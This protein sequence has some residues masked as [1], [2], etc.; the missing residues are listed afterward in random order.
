MEEKEKE[1]NKNTIQS[2]SEV[3]KS[4]LSLSI[5]NRKLALANA[6]RVLAE[7]ENAELAYKY[8]VVQLYMKYGLSKDH[9]ITDNGEILLKE[10]GEN[11]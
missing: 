10:E 9:V 3:D 6:Q 5:M 2:L 11:E 7:Q 8:L 1:D 4:K